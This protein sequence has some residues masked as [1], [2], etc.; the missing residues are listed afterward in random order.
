MRGLGGTECG[1]H[2]GRGHLAVGGLPVVQP[3]GVVLRVD[4]G[5]ATSKH[6]TLDS[7]CSLSVRTTTKVHGGKHAGDDSVD[8]IVGAGPVCGE[9]DH[10]V[11]HLPNSYKETK[12]LARLKYQISDDVSEGCQVPDVLVTSLD[13]V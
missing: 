10:V 5:T 6:L 3:A 2:T 12:F 11:P 4:W 1:G 7:E 8:Q 13:G 9:E